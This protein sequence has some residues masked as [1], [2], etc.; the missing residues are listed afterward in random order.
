MLPWPR[1][2]IEVSTVIATVGTE[3]AGL[4]EMEGEPAGIEC[5]G[6]EELGR[7]PEAS[8]ASIV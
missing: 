1:M 4:L 8:E 7:E 5:L 3:E 6:E 2:L